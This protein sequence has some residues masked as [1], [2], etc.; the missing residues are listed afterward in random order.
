MVFPTWHIRRH[1]HRGVDTCRGHL[2][3]STAKCLE[4]GEELAEDA[5][6]WVRLLSKRETRVTSSFGDLS[7]EI[8][9]AFSRA[10]RDALTAGEDLKAMVESKTIEP[11]VDIDR[12]GWVCGSRYASNTRT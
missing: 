1:G 9:R 8:L 2:R 4:Y 3:G 11:V 10:I 7:L 5:L 6:A 12:L